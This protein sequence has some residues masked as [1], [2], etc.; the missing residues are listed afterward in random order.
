MGLLKEAVHAAERKMRSARRW[1]TTCVT[2]DWPEWR[3][4]RRRGPRGPRI[5]MYNSVFGGRYPLVTNCPVACSNIDRAAHIVFWCHTTPSS[6]LLYQQIA[7]YYVSSYSTLILE[8]CSY[9]CANSWCYQFTSVRCFV[10]LLCELHPQSAFFSPSVLHSQSVIS[11]LA[12]ISTQYS[13]KWVLRSL[14]TSL[15][16]QFSQFSIY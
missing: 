3:R 4:C 11:S 16:L 2:Y 13:F 1:L 15:L 6:T 7:L 14:V 9:Q 8:L 10:H 5:G 12:I